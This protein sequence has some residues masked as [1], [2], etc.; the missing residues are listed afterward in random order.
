MRIVFLPI[1]GLCVFVL[2][3][4]L[5]FLQQCSKGADPRVPEP[6]ISRATARFLMVQASMSFSSGL[7]MGRDTCPTL[8]ERSQLRSCVSQPPGLSVSRIHF[9]LFLPAAKLL[10]NSTIKHTYRIFCDH[11][12][13]SDIIFPSK[14]TNVLH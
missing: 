7:M 4:C 2:R 14:K 1:I 3:H 8:V 9:F 10:L 6:E 11:T 12:S 5:G 13:H